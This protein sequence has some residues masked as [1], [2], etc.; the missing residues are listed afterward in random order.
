M[1][2]PDRLKRLTT[3]PAAVAAGLLSVGALTALVTLLAWALIPMFSGATP[4][5]ITS[6]SMQPVIRAGD[7][8]VTEVPGDVDNLRA[9]TVITFHDPTMDRDISHRIVGSEDG[10]YVT[11]GDANLA[12]DS[13]RVERSAIRGVA[14]RLVPFIGLPALW[15][16]DRRF[17]LLIVLAI[18][19]ALLARGTALGQPG[20]KPG[21]SG[22]VLDDTSAAEPNGDETGPIAIAMNRRRFAKGNARAAGAAVILIV[23]ATA[24]AGPTR[25][26][27]AAFSATT[28]TG[29]SHLAAAVLGAPTITSSSNGLCSATFNWAAVPAP[30]TG[31]EWRS[32]ITGPPTGGWTPTA[33]LTRTIGVTGVAVTRTVYF[34][35][36]SV[37]TATPWVSASSAASRTWLLVACL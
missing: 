10:N 25:L 35:V 33:S 17:D 36:R 28:S 23:L 19:L 3:R 6:G 9:T 30:A 4:R 2:D 37:R 8:L 1:G 7:V 5:V 22:N 11:K 20:A 27:S 26:A 24:V 18:A 31:Y 14:Q 12:L 29:P 32:S 15:L 13:D 21:R 34:E 16:H